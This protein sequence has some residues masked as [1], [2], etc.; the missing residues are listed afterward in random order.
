MENQ[1]FPKGV[2]VVKLVQDGTPVNCESAL[3]LKNAEIL[4]TDEVLVARFDAVTGEK[5]FVERE[6][7]I[8]LHRV[9][10]IEG[11]PGTSPWSD[12]FEVARKKYE[13][14]RRK[15]EKPAPLSP[16]TGKPI[17]KA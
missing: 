3:K 7:T 10:V 13:G 8:P 2:V 6:N 17:P 16:V 11:E 4:L 14:A 1:Y 15:A 5:K 12:D 9:A